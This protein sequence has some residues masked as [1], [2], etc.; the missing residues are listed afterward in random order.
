MS[1]TVLTAP[2][3]HKAQGRSASA[4]TAVLE[5]PRAPIL[6]AMRD[7]VLFTANY[8]FALTSAII[9]YGKSQQS[10]S[11]LHAVQF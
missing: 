11:C 2:V 10:F 4:V 5:K 1:S 9:C 8:I 6:I 7:F 3:S